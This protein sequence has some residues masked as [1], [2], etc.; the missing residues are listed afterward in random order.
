MLYRD[1][2]AI[3]MFLTIIIVVGKMNVFHNFM[4]SSLIVQTVTIWNQA[5]MHIVWKQLI[6]LLDEIF[7]TE[8]VLKYIHNFVLNFVQHSY[9]LSTPGGWELRWNIILIRN[10]LY[11]ERLAI[12]MFLTIIIVDGKMNMFHNFMSSSQ[13]FR[14]TIWNQV[15]M[16]IHLGVVYLAL[17][18]IFFLLK[19]C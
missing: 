14:L 10:M 2:P 4:S 6:Q 18:N 15:E 17:M 3:A 5:E 11:R 19:V 16:H 13:Q 9:N 8:S 12:A 7:F 1:R